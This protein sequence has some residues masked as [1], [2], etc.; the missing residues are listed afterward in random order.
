MNLDKIKKEIQNRLLSVKD[1]KLKEREAC[2]PREPHTTNH[3]NEENDYKSTIFAIRDT[4]VLGFIVWW[5][6]MILKT[7][8][9][10][11]KLFET[12][13]IIKASSEAA[14]LQRKAEIIRL[15]EHIVKISAEVADL[16]SRVKTNS[17]E[18]SLVVDTEPYCDAVCLP[19]ES[20]SRDDGDVLY[21]SFE[22]VFR[23]TESEILLRQQKYVSYSLEAYNNTG[24]Y[25]LDVGCGRGEFLKILDK[26]FV[27]AKGLDISSL[28]CKN[29]KKQ[30]F[31]VECVDAN[32]FLDGLDDNTLSGISALQLIEHLTH[33]DLKKFIALA[34]K[35]TAK[36]GV[37]VLETVNTKSISS[38][39]NFYLDMSHR[40]PLPTELMKF[41]LEWYGFKDI[42]IVYSSP[43]VE[44]L[45]VRRLNEYNYM[46]YAVIG[47]KR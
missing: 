7:P 37:I 32:T 19:E 39:S 17:F 1:A 14:E 29:L 5:V 41:L 30:G 28:S 25:F 4:P 35:K 11:N 6:Y 12:S 33:D 42:Q 2:R 27:S 46:D 40:K 3:P 10:I 45:R 38:L 13:N 24:K 15:E 34:F 9:K 26:A 20:A 21:L 22:N 47:W 16:R 31:D 43:C 8:G 44:E 23:G 18:D 36:G